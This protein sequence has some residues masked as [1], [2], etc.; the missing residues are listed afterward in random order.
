MI[1]L[2]ISVNSGHFCRQNSKAK[3]G[4]LWQI[5]LLGPKAVDLSNVF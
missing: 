4:I 1:N 2:D 5:L 3:P